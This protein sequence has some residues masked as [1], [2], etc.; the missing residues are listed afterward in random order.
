VLLS[1]FGS[2]AGFFIVQSVPEPMALTVL[3]TGL[4]GLALVRR[5]RLRAAT[6]LAA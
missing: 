4:L 6:D 1:P 3:G 2:G 5:G